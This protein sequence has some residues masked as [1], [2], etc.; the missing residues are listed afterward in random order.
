MCIHVYVLQ[1]WLHMKIRQWSRN[2]HYQA[3]P[4]LPKDILSLNKKTW[5]T[6]PNH[7]THYQSHIQT[8][9]HSGIWSQTDTTNKSSGDSTKQHNS[10]T[11]SREADQDF[12]LLWYKIRTQRYVPCMYT[13]R[14]ATDIFI[15]IFK[16]IFERWEH[17][18][19]MW[20]WIV[21][22]ILGETFVPIP[23]STWE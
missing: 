10:A 3:K 17:W 19:H 13:G 14:S 4:V 23:G 7:I 5:N 22:T 11:S 2:G 6:Y 9:R 15:Q 20:G 8:K 18:I 12:W 1:Y 16:C 21:L